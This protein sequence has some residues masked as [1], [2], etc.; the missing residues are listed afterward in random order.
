[1]PMGDAHWGDA[2]GR[3]TVRGL[4]DENSRVKQFIVDLSLDVD[5][6]VLKGDYVKR[7]VEFYRA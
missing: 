3:A 1:M 6:D 2:P 5:K 4:E 7:P